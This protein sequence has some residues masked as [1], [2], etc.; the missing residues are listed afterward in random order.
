MYNKDNPNRADTYSLIRESASKA[1]FKIVDGGTGSVRLGRPP[2]RRQLRCHHLRLDQLG[3][4]VSGVPQIFKRGNDPNF[5]GFKSAE[6]DKLMDEVIVTTD[7]GQAGRAD[8]P[9]RQAHL[10]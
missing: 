7:K 5:N 2:G 6:A 9:D 4:G 1:G 10:G 8:H 3:V